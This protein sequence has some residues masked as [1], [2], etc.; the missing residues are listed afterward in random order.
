MI[1]PVVVM[2]AS[3]PFLLDVRNLTI[4]CELPV[5]TGDATAREI[6]EAEEA[7]KAHHPKI[8]LKRRRPFPP[9][10]SVLVASKSNY[11]TQADVMKRERC[12]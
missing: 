3:R 5:V 2:I 9:V 10:S 4:G 8:L 11:R 7:N 6:R 1:A 12:W